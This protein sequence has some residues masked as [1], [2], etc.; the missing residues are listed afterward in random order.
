MEKLR[1]KLI[2]NGYDAE[3]IT[4][5]KATGKD[6]IGLRVS[7]VSN[8]EKDEAV[9]GV[10]FYGATIED[11]DEIVA[12]FEKKYEIEK[13]KYREIKDCMKDSDRYILCIRPPKNDNVVVKKFLDL[14]LYVRVDLND[15][16]TI[17][18]THEN[19]FYIDMTEEELFKKAEENSRKTCSV[20]PL[21]YVLGV[22]DDVQDAQSPI[23]IVRNNN[24]FYGASVMAMLDEM[25]DGSVDFFVLPSSIHEI[26]CVPIDMFDEV[27]GLNEMIQ[28]IN[29]TSLEEK[30]VLSNHAYIYENGELQIAGI[31]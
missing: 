12:E 14:E 4:V 29:K 17:A 27:D 2:E 3:I 20:A 9:F 31:L 19:M 24:G 11:Y 13:D 6:E 15:E 21:D 10:I 18:V 25:F 8:G 7:K 26:L 1:D 16:A 5:P 23:I 22:V 28:D 30:D